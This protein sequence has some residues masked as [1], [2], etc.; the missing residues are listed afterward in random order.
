MRYI[1][2]IGNLAKYLKKLM[3]KII[4]ICNIVN[5]KNERPTNQ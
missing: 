5:S 3:L 2:N 1:W 4:L